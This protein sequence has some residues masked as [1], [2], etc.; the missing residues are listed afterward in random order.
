MLKLVGHI[1][2]WIRV[3]SPPAWAVI[4]ALLS[5]LVIEGLHQAMLVIGAHEES[6]KFTQASAGVVIAITA[7]YAIFRGVA[8]HPASQGDYW[9]WL[10]LTPWRDPQPLPLGPVYVVAQDLVIL[11]L[12]ELLLLDAPLDL[13]LLLPAA[14]LFVLTGCWAAWIWYTDRRSAAYEIGYALG[15]TM[16]VASWSLLVACVGLVATYLLAHHRFRQSFASF[17]WEPFRARRQ[18]QRQ[19]G[20]QQRTQGSISSLAVWG[21]TYDVL[22]PQQTEQ[23]PLRDRL[24]LS[25]LVGWCVLAVLAHS[26]YP[27]VLALAIMFSVFSC[28]S[29][30]LQKVMQYI[31]SHAPPISLLGRLATGRWVIPS[32]DVVLAPVVYFAVC[33]A[34]ALFLTGPILEW[35]ARYVLPA[36]LTIYLMLMN[37]A[38]PDLNKWRLTC[39]ARISPWTYAS[40]KREYE[41]L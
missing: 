28:G 25:G 12:F 34:A 15:A 24:W 1:V 16:W 40:N 2:R 6:L 32:Y 21:W 41:Q 11:A 4:L 38:C 33:L 7:A 9:K 13:H 31:W 8:F 20:L 19:S 29:Y 3:V 39:Q 14:F 10:A 27:I 35:P 26:E 37:V 30:T 22:S 17:P 18:Q 36:M 23:L 5:Y